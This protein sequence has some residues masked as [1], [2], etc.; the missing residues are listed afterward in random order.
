MGR[1]F[2]H[3]L[4]RMVGARRLVLLASLV[5]TLFGIVCRAPFTAGAQASS[6]RQR[7]GLSTITGVLLGHS[8]TAADTAPPRD[9]RP[10]MPYVR[11]PPAGP[12]VVR[13]ARAADA[14][15]V[16]AM[17]T[18]SPPR[19]FM[20][21]STRSRPTSSTSISLVAILRAGSLPCHCAGAAIDVTCSI[22]HF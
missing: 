2:S 9:R 19:Q 8:K 12:A 15:G 4:A 13:P 20:T 17:R 14:A 10:L 16:A 5:G 11:H 3:R 21:C 1:Y 18:H 6:P 22:Y 7:P